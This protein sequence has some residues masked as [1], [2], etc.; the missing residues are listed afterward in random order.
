M[1][2]KPV[3][4]SWP[5]PKRVRTRRI[6]HANMKYPAETFE[7]L[8]EGYQPMTTE[9]ILLGTTDYR[10]MF[11]SKWLNVRVSNGLQTVTEKVTVRGNI[12]KAS[13]YVRNHFKNNFV[14]GV[15]INQLIVVLDDMIVEVVGDSNT[16]EF[17]LHGS[18][19]SIDKMREELL[20][21]FEELTTWINWIYDKNMSS[22]QVPL[23]SSRSPID[24]M[25]PWLKN[26]TLEEYYDRY[27]MSS[28][29]ILILYGPQE[30]GK[31]VSSVD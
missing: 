16:I 30:L 1:S 10:D 27:M 9:P 26:E 2:N 13:A 20:I 28:S 14:F 19:T 31:Q 6:D 7:Y 17:R 15:G 24:E 8:D 18:F 3:T 25:Y 21:D 12:P 11:I 5:P 29:S 22:V 4:Y 23:D